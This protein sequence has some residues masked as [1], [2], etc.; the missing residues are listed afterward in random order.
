MELV[1][2]NVRNE[3]PGVSLFCKSAQGEALSVLVWNVPQEYLVIG[4]DCRGIEEEVRMRYDPLDMGGGKLFWEKK[5][6]M[7]SLEKVDVLQVY[8]PFHVRLELSI[9]AEV[10][11]SFESPVEAFMLLKGISGI[12]RIEVEGDVRGHSI[13]VS[14]QGIRGVGRAALPGMRVCY[15]CPQRIGGE[16]VGFAGVVG[17]SKHGAGMAKN[18][19]EM[20]GSA[21]LLSSEVG[22]ALQKEKEVPP[23]RR[24]GAMADL[25]KKLSDFKVDLVVTHR[26][27]ELERMYEARE[28]EAGRSLF[29]DLHRFVPSIVKMDEFSVEEMYEVFVQGSGKEVPRND[30][31]A[32]VLD[33]RH[34]G[35]RAADM[36]NEMRANALKMAL[37]MER[38]ELLD[39][40][41]HMTNASG[42]LLNTTFA[43]LKSD[44]VEYMLL[45]R[46]RREGYIPPPKRGGTEVHE[47]GHVFLEK[48]G[49]YEGRYIALFDFSSLYPSIILEHSV[50]FSSV[51]SNF[52]SKGVFLPGVVR[53]L[54]EKRREIKERIKMGENARILNV[55]Q[56]AIKLIT[57]CI[58]GCLGFRGFRFYD[59]RIA[60]FIA[61]KGR[62]IL[63]RSKMKIEAMGYRVIYGDTDSVVVD[64]GVSSDKRT[65]L[66][67]VVS[68][69]VS[70]VSGEYTNISLAFEK[71]F[72][73]IV[74]IAKK[75]YIGHYTK[76]CDLRR[77]PVL[78]V[79]KKGLESGRRDWA[80]ISKRAMDRAIVVLLSSRKETR[81]REIVAMLL[82][83]KEEI[84]HAPLEDFLIRKL[85]TKDPAEY[86]VPKA[87]HHVE[88]ALRLRSKGLFLKCGDIVSYVMGKEEGVLR[89]YDPSEHV[90]VDFDYYLRVQI[91]APILRMLV[92]FSEVDAKSIESMRR[93]VG[94]GEPARD[95][96]TDPRTQMAPPCCT[97]SQHIGPVCVRCGEP[98]SL[99]FL[100]EKVSGALAEFARAIYSPSRACPG[101]GGSSP[102]VPI[103]PVCNQQTVWETSS[104]EAFDTFLSVLERAFCGHDSTVSVYLDEMSRRS[105]F[106]VL[107]LSHW[108]LEGVEEHWNRNR[109]MG[110][111]GELD[112]IL[113]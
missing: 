5:R 11:A 38:G 53:E 98:V 43:G 34:F 47:G 73:V 87:F 1:L 76:E 67:P 12:M 110:N 61:E 60:S 111:T 25:L 95:L 32:A 55:E 30:E 77:E 92:H 57:N 68:S 46:M 31:V 42:T 101:C 90:S 85:L 72:T 69:I 2:L 97:V 86:P 113:L 52:R 49:K 35:E 104:P 89:A 109:L 4:T 14:M 78:L 79:E 28:G 21:S 100:L 33:G 20:D 56:N 54:V 74:M 107:D 99:Q 83:V 10:H 16:V 96:S 22:K 63:K 37:V 84:R 58:Y 91:L 71:I 75:K 48:E 66:T 80:R 64:L 6:R 3:G 24:D 13:S 17:G 7:Q 94:I 59:R 39:L 36:L 41:E 50:C 112:R 82:H 44:R 51:D 62:E 9:A 88:L 105:S 106:R 108:T 102:L 19:L 29:C 15:L 70:L 23:I 18:T 45:S 40:A 93:I 27:P 103:C 8:L 65:D 81:A 26:F